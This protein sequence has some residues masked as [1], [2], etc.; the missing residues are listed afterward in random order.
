MAQGLIIIFHLA[1][2]HPQ[3]GSSGSVILGPGNS[4]QQL[5]TCER[6]TRRLGD[7]SDRSH[8]TDSM[9]REIEAYRL[10]LHALGT[11]CS[12]PWLPVPRQPAESCRLTAC[13]LQPPEHNC[14]LVL[15]HSRRPP[16]PCAVTVD[17]QRPDCPRLSSTV[18]GRPRLNRTLIIWFRSVR[19]YHSSRC[20][21]VIDF[22]HPSPNFQGLHSKLNQ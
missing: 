10:G 21:A 19:P 9:D 17:G 15:D 11:F 1:V 5:A 4:L 18:H 3:A 14:N 13:T 22:L 16:A 2:G 8:C 6:A 20:C 12:K 7:N